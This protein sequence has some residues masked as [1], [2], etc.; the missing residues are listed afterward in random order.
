MKAAMSLTEAAAE[1]PW[2]PD[3]LRKAIH[4]AGVDRDGRPTFPP[5]LI[6]GMA[7]KKY[8][9]LE[10]DLRAWLEEIRLTWPA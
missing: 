6:A 4:T 1:T 8:F 3:I 2:S 5:P 9:I 7:G 10:A